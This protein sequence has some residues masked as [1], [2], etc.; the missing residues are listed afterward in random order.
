M[1]LVVTGCDVFLV[2]TCE[3]LESDWLKVL[4]D[5][6]QKTILPVGLLPPSAQ[7]SM[8]EHDDTWQEIRGWLDKQKKSSVVYVAPGTEATPSQAELT[9]LALGALAEKNVG[10]EVPRNESD[11]SLTRQSVAES[12]SLVM[13]EERGRIHREKAREM[14]SIFGDMDLQER[15]LDNF[16]CY[17]QNH[18]SLHKSVK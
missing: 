16:I 12:L 5:L 6:Q 17:L 18:K 11:G 3:E 1:G 4:G 2:R 8:D 15:C 14:S 9:E 10:V 13:V 7:G